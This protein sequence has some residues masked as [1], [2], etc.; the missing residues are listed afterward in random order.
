[1][2][3]VIIIGAGPA[4]FTSAIYA[5]RREMKTLLIGKE[6]GG[7]IMWASEIEN[8]PGFLSISSFDLIYKLQEHVKKNNVE[9]KIED[10]VKINKLDDSSFE[11]ITNK[12]KYYSKTV[13]LALGL[14]PRKLNVKGETE[15]LGKGVTYCANCDG[16][17]YR[18]KVVAV[19][20]GGNSAV[21]AAEV[22]SKIAKKVYLINRTKNFKA[23]ESLVNKAKNTKNIEFLVNAEIIEI[24]GQNKVE[25]IDVKFKDKDLIKIIE[26]DGVFIEVGRIAKSD[27]LADLI[28]KDERNQII[29]DEYCSTSIK[30]IF[31]AG[32]I[33]QVPFK[34]ITIAT[35]QAAI[36]A[37]S[38]YQFLQMK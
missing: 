34:Q 19:V 35:G 37:L 27:F 21:D 9:I 14:T 29:V 11:I 4:G 7:Q 17:F 32:D 12:E 38:A 24:K 28:K 33:T 10:V 5:S 1:M 26:L 16:P 13:I 6:L 2:Y 23:F 15:F 3:D 36:A 25:T 20:G 18:N 31:A 8:Y 22:L 30:G